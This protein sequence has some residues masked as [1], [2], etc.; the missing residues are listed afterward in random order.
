M[1]TRRSRWESQSRD[2]DFPGLRQNQRVQ[3]DQLAIDVDERASA[4]AGIDRRVGL[5]IDGRLIRIGLTGDGAHHA[6]RDRIAQPFRTAEREH[7]FALADGV[8]VGQ[9]D[10]PEARHVDLQQREVDVARGADDSRV[11]GAAGVLGQRFAPG[12]PPSCRGAGSPV[13]VWRRRRHARW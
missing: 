8:V 5:N 13:R 7:E 12:R 1:P 6:H 3:S 9:R 2:P 10:R 4:V 11:D